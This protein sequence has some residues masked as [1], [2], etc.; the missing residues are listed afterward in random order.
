MRKTILVALG[1]AVCSAASAQGADHAVNV[2]NTGK[3]PVI[4]LTTSDPG[5]NDWGADLLGTRT[6]GPG[7]TITVQV[8]GGACQVDVQAVLDDG[9][10]VEKTGVEIC[11]AD[12][13]VSL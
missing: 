12:A 10:T 1:L 3:I 13:S 6:I 4:A 5:K 7:K 9:G 8:K 2:T 11:A